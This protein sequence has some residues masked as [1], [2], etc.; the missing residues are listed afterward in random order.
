LYALVVT[1]EEVK[2]ERVI[3]K[4]SRRV[5]VRRGRSVEFMYSARPIE[6]EVCMKCLQPETCP[7]TG[8]ACLVDQVI[9]ETLIGLRALEYARVKGAKLV[10]PA[11]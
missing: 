4:F 6:R 5:L 7:L 10:F 2:A 1:R 9:E 3:R 11:P 8:K